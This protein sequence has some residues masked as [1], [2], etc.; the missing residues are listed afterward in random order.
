MYG[1]PQAGYPQYSG[2]PQYAAGPQGYGQPGYAV[3]QQAA[4]TAETAPAQP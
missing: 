2:Y 4:A 1:M 3:P